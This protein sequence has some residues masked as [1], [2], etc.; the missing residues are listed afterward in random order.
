MTGSDGESV[1]E[2]LEA[3]L[4]S[5]VHYDQ[6]DQEGTEAEAVGGT[7]TS[8]YQQ[9][10]DDA[11]GSHSAAEMNGDKSEAETETTR[12]FRSPETVYFHNSETAL[13]KTHNEVKFDLDGEL[14]I[15]RVKGKNVT[16]TKKRKT[17]DIPASEDVTSISRVGSRVQ[18]AGN[19]VVPEASSKVK[20]NKSVSISKLKTKEE[21]AP[22]PK[23]S[24]SVKGTEKLPPTDFIKLD[25]FNSLQE[26]DYRKTLSRLLTS[27]TSCNTVKDIV[28]VGSNS[29]CS[30]SSS[31]SRSS[32][33]STTSNKS[34]NEVLDESDSESSTSDSPSDSDMQVLGDTLL[35][36]AAGSNS[37]KQSLDLNWNVN[38]ADRETIERIENTFAKGMNYDFIL[39]HREG[40]V[41]RQEQSWCI[42]TCACVKIIQISELCN[43]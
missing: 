43:C 14:G 13:V 23:A 3:M 37:T 18:T 9:T 26:S 19:I 40:F 33:S 42:Y 35:D 15:N 25:T 34:D 41:N 11:V 32:S 38:S 29:S 12:L 36:R 20:E 17:V 10:D 2:E 39:K 5:Q 27:Q 6:G 21:N 31:S 4:Y 22:T 8:Y 7:L 30:S 28:T 16:K 24:V 1:D